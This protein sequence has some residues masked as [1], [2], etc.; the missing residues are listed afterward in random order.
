MFYI[1]V[2]LLLNPLFSTLLKPCQNCIYY[3]KPFFN[4]KYEIGNYFGKCLKFA[5]NHTQELDYKYALQVRINEKECGKDGKYFDSGMPIDII[6][7]L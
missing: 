4:D 2:F 7:S 3:I 1:I 5:N 6:P